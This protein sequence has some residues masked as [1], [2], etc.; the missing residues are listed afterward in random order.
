MEM[1]LISME[2]YQE[3]SGEIIV[4][5]RFGEIFIL[6][7]NRRDFIVPMKILLQSDYAEAYKACEEMNKGAE[8]NHMYF[9][10]LN[11]RQFLKCNFGPYDNILDIDE[12]GIFHCEFINCPLR[13]TCKYNN[14]ICSPTFTTRLTDSDIVIIRM[15]VMQHMT[16]DQ[17]A[18][19]LFRSVNTINNRRKIILK[20]TGCKDIAQ[21]VGYC[22]EH[23]I[24]K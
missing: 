14:V 18:L 8:P 5:P 6:K 23:N 4:K 3:P 2:F 20:K 1:E 11:V 22:Y 15:I 10:F 24:L 13:G 19:T 12:S 9:D 7:Q 21:L 16:A 17:I